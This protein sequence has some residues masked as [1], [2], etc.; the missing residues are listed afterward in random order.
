MVSTWFKVDVHSVQVWTLVLGFYFV[1]TISAKPDIFQGN[2]Y[3]QLQ[4]TTPLEI[5]KHLPLASSSNTVTPLINP[6]KTLYG[7]CIETKIEA[8]TNKSYQQH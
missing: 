4:L 1:E 3:K 2:Q 7:K 5:K 6:D 8:L